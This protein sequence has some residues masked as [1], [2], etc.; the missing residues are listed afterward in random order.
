[1]MAENSPAKE[2]IRIVFLIAGDLSWES[3]DKYPTALYMKVRE[4]KG[5]N[6]SHKR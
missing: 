4:G 1:M 5:D 6:I 3:H 2:K